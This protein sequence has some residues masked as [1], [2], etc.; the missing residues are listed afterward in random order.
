MSRTKEAM[1]EGGEFGEVEDDGFISVDMT[2][3]VCD[4][5]GS[6]P[7]EHGP[8][9]PYSCPNCTTDEPRSPQQY[10]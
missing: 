10:P 1:I 9:F 5:T 8:Q 3:P 4:G 2:C 7:S 6:V